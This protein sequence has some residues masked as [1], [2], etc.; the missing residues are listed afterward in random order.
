MKIQEVRKQ[1][2]HA[3][4]AEEKSAVAEQAPAPAAHVAS[5]CRSPLPRAEPLSPHASLPTPSS[6]SAMV[7]SASARTVAKGV[8]RGSYGQGPLPGR[9]KKGGGGVG[10][11]S[12][13]RGGVA[14]QETERAN[15]VALEATLLWGCPGEV[16][17]RRSSRAKVGGLGS[18]PVVS[19]CVLCM[20]CVNDV[21]SFV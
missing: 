10:P 21:S 9:G 14:A 11:Q 4:Q 17:H 3:F 6:S 19:R 12:R 2:S 13:K 7:F 18:A 20:H 5:Q 16:G 8:P 15:G 1:A